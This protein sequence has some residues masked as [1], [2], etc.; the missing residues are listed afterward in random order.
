M[1]SLRARGC[2][3][4]SG[5]HTGPGGRCCGRAVPEALLL[6]SAGLLRRLRSAALSG[7]NSLAPP[8]LLPWLCSLQRQRHRSPRSGEAFLWLSLRW[9]WN[10]LAAASSRSILP[11][12]PPAARSVSSA[13]S[14]MSLCLPKRPAL[15]FVPWCP[16][17]LSRSPARCQVAAGGDS[18]HLL[19]SMR[20]QA[21]GCA[22]V[23]GWQ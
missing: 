14:R 20:A 5:Q 11:Q 18:C 2:C 4:P 17:E 9:Q 23:G 19:T 10:P 21:G 1:S 15:C 16:S 8:A 6:P 13:C 22:G 3:S 12:H 7:V